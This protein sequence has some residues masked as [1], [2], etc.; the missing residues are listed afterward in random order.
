MITLMK[1]TEVQ[2][3]CANNAGVYVKMRITQHSWYYVISI[4]TCICTKLYSWG[5]RERAPPLMM[6]TALT[7][8]RPSSYVSQTAHVRYSRDICGFEFC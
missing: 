5:E 7:S 8:V 1:S 4:G 3:L 2:T 6:S